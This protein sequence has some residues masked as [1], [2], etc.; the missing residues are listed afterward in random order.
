M[1]SK[2]HCAAKSERYCRL[3]VFPPWQQRIRRCGESEGRCSTWR[4]AGREP[5]LG[6]KPPCS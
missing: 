3:G 2:C 1:D 6:P 5:L 4:D